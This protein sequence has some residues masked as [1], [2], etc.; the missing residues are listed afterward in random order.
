MTH[1]YVLIRWVRE[2]LH[3]LSSDG[4]QV[5]WL[6]G[7]LESGQANRD[8]LESGDIINPSGRIRRDIR[9]KKPHFS[10]PIDSTEPCRPLSCMSHTKRGKT[11]FIGIYLMVR[12][13]ANTGSFGYIEP[14]GV[15]VG[16]GSP[17]GEKIRLS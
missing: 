8:F 12:Y 13:T 17:N 14:D 6:G 9:T 3:P 1:Q 2:V 11:A 4:R 15:C 7:L 10:F 16:L 5:R